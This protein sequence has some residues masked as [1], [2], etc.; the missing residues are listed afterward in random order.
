M[1]GTHPIRAGEIG[2]P[3][4]MSGRSLL[5]GPFCTAF[6]ALYHSGFLRGIPAEGIGSVACPAA[7]QTHTPR[8]SVAWSPHARGQVRA[9]RLEAS[10]AELAEPETRCPRRFILLNENAIRTP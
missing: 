8:T 9:R 2:G 5:G 4:W 6:D 1:R 10:L 7:T 3:G